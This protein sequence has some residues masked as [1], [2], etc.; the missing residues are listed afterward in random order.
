MDPAVDEVWASDGNRFQNALEHV[1]GLQTCRFKPCHGSSVKPH[2]QKVVLCSLQILATLQKE[3]PVAIDGLFA[4]SFEM[5]HF[6][7]ELWCNMRQ[8]LRSEN[9]LPHSAEQESFFWR[10]KQAGAVG[11]FDAEDP[12]V[13]GMHSCTPVVPKRS[14]VASV[15]P[16][17][18]RF[19][20][21]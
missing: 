1:C 12:V 6:G 16:P 3:L 9:L 17:N 2:P 7:C 13:G 10:A 19:A 11:S 21:L 14:C 18:P 5:R 20:G 4:E 15:Q 8:S